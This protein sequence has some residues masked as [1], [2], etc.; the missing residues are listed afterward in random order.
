MID[1]EAM[2]MEKPSDENRRS[3]TSGDE[4]DSRVEQGPHPQKLILTALGAMVVLVGSGAYWW[5]TFSHRVPDAHCLVPGIEC[6]QKLV[7]VMEEVSDV[8]RTASMGESWALALLVTA[9]TFVVFYVHICR[10]EEERARTVAERKSEEKKRIAQEQGESAPDIISRSKGV[11]GA[12]RVWFVSRWCIPVFCYIPAVLLFGGEIWEGYTDAVV[13]ALALAAI[14]VAAE[15]YSALE[16]QRKLV[17]EQE[18]VLETI[19]NE[20]SDK[21]ASID[22]AMGTRYGLRVIYDAYRDPNHDQFRAEE[23]KRL[24]PGAAQAHGGAANAQ[25]SEK[26]IFS[27]YRFFDID[28]QWWARESWQGYC[29]SPAA[30]LYRTLK[31][32]ARTKM[33]LVTPL[34]YPQ[35]DDESMQD[36]AL[37]FGKFIGLVWH[38]VV[39]W[40]VRRALEADSKDVVCEHKIR[41]AQTSLWLHVVDRTV[42]QILGDDRGKDVKVRN[43]THDMDEISV[44]LARWAKRE[45]QTLAARGPT[46]EEYICTCLTDAH[47]AIPADGAATFG[48]NED[49]VLERLGFKEWANEGD[50]PS[51]IRKR[52]L[53]ARCKGLIRDAVAIIATSEPGKRRSSTASTI[54]RS[55]RLQRRSSD[56]HFHRC[57]AGRPGDHQ[58][59]GDVHRGADEKHRRVEFHDPDLADGQAPSGRRAL[60]ACRSRRARSRRQAQGLRRRAVQGRI[61]QE[62]ARRPAVDAGHSSRALSGESVL[63][64]VANRGIARPL[65]PR[66]A[67][68]RAVGSR[69][70]LG[71]RGGR[72]TAE[73]HLRGEG[74]R[75]HRAIVAQ[76]ASHAAGA[77]RCE[78]ARQAQGVDGSDRPF[79]LTNDPVSRSDPV[80]RRAAGTAQF[81]AAGA[82]VDS[83]PDGDR[84]H[85]R[86][87]V[88]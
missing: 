37:F 7:A 14:Y 85:R 87:R 33:T 42:Y 48:Q 9:F 21:V 43:L 23:R 44:S 63:C 75:R 59:A 4:S 61:G 79:V 15:H 45:I 19:R 25:E 66:R 2:R 49:H 47:Q 17:D 82:S 1:Q 16:Q 81:G 28:K 78:R 62:T 55:K 13:L 70:D 26:G 6:V 76:V 73:R 10:A 11:V 41:I 58:R 68:R 8:D 32:G 51:G 31:E 77:S 80:G 27:I 29:S 50:A 74:D 54:R 72:R 64:R 40:H 60:A 18:A 53:A 3:R 39:L 22:N 86:G 34:E 30:T 46:V 84:T 65:L 83:Q 38:Y 67:D 24:Q 35:F 5:L 88:G 12:L 57:D 52:V 36:K 56:E 69:A 20:L 71:R